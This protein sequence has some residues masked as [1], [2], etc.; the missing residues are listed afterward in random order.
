MTPELAKTL[1]LLGLILII[2]G[3]LFLFQPN[4]PWFG[5]L[6]GDIA[7]KRENFS[8]YFPLTT[9]ILIS[10]IVTIIFSLFRK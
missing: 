5:R 4:I 7:V 8:F 1:I 9:S 6:P 10:I 2:I 3:G